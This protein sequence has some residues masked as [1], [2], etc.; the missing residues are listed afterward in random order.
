VI[1]DVTGFIERMKQR[2]ATVRGIR[3]RLARDFGMRVPAS[4]VADALRF[5][6]PLD[7][8]RTPRQRGRS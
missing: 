4:T 8:S 5:M 3:A 6:S 2:P 7:T 1:E